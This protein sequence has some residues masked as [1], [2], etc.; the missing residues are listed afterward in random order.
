MTS[1]T[2]VPGLPE[3]QF[4]PL[5]ELEDDSYSP[6]NPMSEVAKPP[7]IIIN[8]DEFEELLRQHFG[9][10]KVHLDIEW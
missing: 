9:A 3:P 10:K 6:G 8:K 7:H 4:R 2:P 5:T 1:R